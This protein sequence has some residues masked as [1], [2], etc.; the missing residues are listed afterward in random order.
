MEQNLVKVTFEF[1]NGITM[2][3][4]GASL[5]EWEA[6]QERLMA[7]AQHGLAALEQEK[8][9]SQEQQVPTAPS[10][11]PQGPINLAAAMAQRAAEGNQ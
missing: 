2:I 1:D 6:T 10:P 9:K 7:M 8:A 4:K 5:R 3:R 11:F